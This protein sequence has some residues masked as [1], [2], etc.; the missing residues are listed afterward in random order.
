VITKG[1]K[2]KGRLAARQAAHTM[3][4]REAKVRVRWASGGYTRPGSFKKNFP[5]QG[6]YQAGKSRSHT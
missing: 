5:K 3:T 2:V 4:S 1:S 6:R